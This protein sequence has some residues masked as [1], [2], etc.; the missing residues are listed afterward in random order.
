MKSQE[1]AYGEAMALDNLARTYEYM[2][3]VTKAYESLESVSDPFF[4]IAVIWRII[5]ML[6]KF[7]KCCELRKLIER[8]TANKCCHTKSKVKG[9]HKT[10][11]YVNEWGKS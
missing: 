7:R 11:L 3:N 6:N 9:L 8:H 1:N 10:K 5:F 2:A 4:D